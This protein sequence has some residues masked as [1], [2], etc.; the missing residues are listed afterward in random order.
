M[1]KTLNSSYITVSYESSKI[2]NSYQTFK[3][4]FDY[5]LRCSCYCTGHERF[6]L[7]IVM[8]HP[9]ICSYID[10]QYFLQNWIIDFYTKSNSLIPI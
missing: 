2:Y 3:S 6:I 5:K 8:K 1:F 7:N 10:A 4:T 9:V